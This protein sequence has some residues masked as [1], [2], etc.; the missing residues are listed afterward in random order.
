[1]KKEE[2]EL[3][4]VFLYK[5]RNKE[6]ERIEAEAWEELSCGNAEE[7]TSTRKTPHLTLR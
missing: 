1:M 3:E 2:G 4:R 6:L 7:A 5:K